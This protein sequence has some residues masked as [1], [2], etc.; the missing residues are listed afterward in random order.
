[1]GADALEKAV[2]S[3]SIVA[4]NSEEETRQPEGE[5]GKDKGEDKGESGKGSEDEPG[6][7]KGEG[8]DTSTGDQDSF[9]SGLSKQLEA[10]NQSIQGMGQ[11]GTPDGQ[12]AE[13]AQAR[14]FDA[15]LAALQQQAEDGDISYQELLMQ[16]Q[17]IQ[18]AKTQQQ[19]QEAIGQ[20][21]QQKQV[22][23]VRERFLAENPDFNDFIQSD[24]N[25]AMQQSNP[26]LD[27][28]SAYFANKAQAQGQQ[29]AALQQE[30]AALK[31]ERESS[32]A[33]AAGQQTSKVGAESGTDI[34]EAAKSKNKNLSAREG[35]MAALNAVRQ[36]NA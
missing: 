4:D 20:Y 2:P 26:V 5:S 1:M 28:V 35:M 32:I 29:L 14:D 25:T 27:N 17:A 31:A 9:M 18:E 36:A 13:Q 24:Q 7:S 12:G 30:L 16:S 10:L 8:K 22:A 19:V 33:G 11:S 21:D 23:E 6:A 34:K 3:G 15:E